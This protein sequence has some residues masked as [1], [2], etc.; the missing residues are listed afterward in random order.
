MQS[1][2][3]QDVE[4]ADPSCFLRCCLHVHQSEAKSLLQKVGLRMTFW[5][6]TRELFRELGNSHFSIQ[7]VSSF[8]SWSM[9]EAASHLKTSE[10]ANSE[11]RKPASTQEE[12]VLPLPA[13][14]FSVAQGGWK[15]NTLFSNDLG[16]SFKYSDKVTMGNQ[17]CLASWKHNCFSFQQPHPSTGGEDLVYL[18]L[19]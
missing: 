1:S 8:K 9:L 3:H 17:P 6:S 12:A 5:D 16:N 10:K 2:Y 19:F 13:P 15:G 4:I 7:K 18:V 11:A 14:T